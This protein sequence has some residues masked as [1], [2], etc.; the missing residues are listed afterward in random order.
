MRSRFEENA[1]VGYLGKTEY[2]N[3]SVIN[4]R[5]VTVVSSTIHGCH[6]TIQTKLVGKDDYP[7]SDPPS[8][9]PSVSSCRYET[10]NLE[11]LDIIKTIGKIF[12]A[13]FFK[14]CI[15]ISGRLFIHNSYDMYRQAR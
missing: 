2:R 15:T 1:F 3:Q 4:S 5:P 12:G 9:T 14:H 6:T 8:P 7:S 10:L 13:H 11:D